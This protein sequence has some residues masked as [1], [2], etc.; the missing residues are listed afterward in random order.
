VGSIL[1]TTKKLTKQQQSTGIDT[2][3]NLSPVLRMVASTE[4]YNFSDYIW[5]STDLNLISIV[6]KSG[7]VR[8]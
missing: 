2:G 4:F 7:L 8:G 5:F 1:S 3:G 6:T